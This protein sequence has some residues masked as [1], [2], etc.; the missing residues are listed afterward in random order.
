[1]VK[2]GAPGVCK[3][4]ARKVMLFVNWDIYKY[5]SYTIRRTWG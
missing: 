5:L 1:M 3:V 4:L 2:K